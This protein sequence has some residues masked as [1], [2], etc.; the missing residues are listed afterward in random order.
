MGNR[1][2][3]SNPTAQR[4][5]FSHDINSGT[6]RK[7]FVRKSKRRS[8]E[9]KGHGAE[10]SMHGVEGWIDGSMHGAVGS[11]HGAEGSIHGGEGS[12]NGRKRIDTRRRRIDARRFQRSSER[13]NTDVDIRQGSSVPHKNTNFYS[14]NGVKYQHFAVAMCI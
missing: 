3:N 5:I 12:M 10:G 6:E 7:N 2:S 13:P 11:I 4:C 8:M 14:Y 1:N 9:G